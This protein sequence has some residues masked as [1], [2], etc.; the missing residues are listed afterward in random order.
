M[1]NKNKVPCVVGATGL[2]GS[3]LISHL[4]KIYPQVISIT[5]TKTD[6]SS[7]IV[8]NIV[9]DFDNIMNKDLFDKNNDLYIALGTTRRKAGSDQNFIKVDYDYCINLAKNAFNSGVKRISVI[10]SVGTNPNSKLL[11]P[12]TKGLLEM[13]LSK[14]PFKHIS[15]MKPGLILGL[16]KETRIAE[17]I[18]KI[19]FSFI[20]PFLFFGL[21]KYK[22]VHANDIAKAM[23]YQIGGENIGINKIE[24]KDIIACSKKVIFK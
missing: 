15:I 13:E 19:L 4:S 10:S 16:R 5:R 21:S 8:K 14:L 22:S 6:Y 2:V 18:G 11:Y 3:H 17:K 20:N 24:Y 23:I 7:S 1:F 9:L 12:K